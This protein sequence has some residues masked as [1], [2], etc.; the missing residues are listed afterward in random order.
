MKKRKWKHPEKPA[1]DAIVFDVLHAIKG[2]KASEIAAQTWVSQSTIAKWR[3]G[4]EH[5]GTRWP[6]H[7]TL[8]AV[9]AVAGLE[10][11]LVRSNEIIDLKE[12][13]NERTSTVKRMRA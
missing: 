8:A 6:Q 7:A 12:K 2:R 1:Y 4:Y 13:R 3:L 10:F 9:A 5:G 11:R